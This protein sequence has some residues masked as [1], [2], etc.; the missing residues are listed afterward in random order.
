MR[1][2][3]S[4]E[5]FLSLDGTCLICAQLANHHGKA[6][7]IQ[8]KSDRPASTKCSGADSGEYSRLTFTSFCLIKSC[9]GEPGPFTGRT[10][11]LIGSRNR[12]IKTGAKSRGSRSLSIWVALRLTSADRLMRAKSASARDEPGE[13]I[14]PSSLTAI[15]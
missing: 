12:A 15:F 14:W 2:A 8:R 4:T 7:G 11:Y 1:R 13:S 9:P 5:M 10:S 6:V 3:A